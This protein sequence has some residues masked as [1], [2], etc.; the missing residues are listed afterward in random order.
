MY[1]LLATPAPTPSR[2]RCANILLDTFRYPARGVSGKQ[3]RVPF[4]P[5]GLAALQPACSALS[6]LLLRGPGGPFVLLLALMIPVS[7]LLPAVWWRAFHESFQR[8]DACKF[9]ETLLVQKHPYCTLHFSVFYLSFIHLFFPCL[10]TCGIFS[11]CLYSEIPCSCALLGIYIYCAE[12]IKPPSKLET[13]IL[14][15]HFLN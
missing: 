15:D 6:R 3:S 1:L 13:Q 9:F 14:G 8:R 2:H 4:V 5:R 11:L 12:H 10:E 7:W